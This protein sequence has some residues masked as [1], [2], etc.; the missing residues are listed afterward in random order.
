MNARH[1]SPTNS[2]S[3]RTVRRWAV[4]ITAVTLPLWAGA[5]PVARATEP[6]HR[7]GADVTRV[8]WT[9]AVD[10][11]GSTFRIVTSDP[12]GAHT[13]PLTRP[14]AE[15]QDIHA[16][17]SPDGRTVLFER[18]NPDGSV[19]IMVVGADGRNERV[20]HLGCVDPCASDQNASWTPD[21]RHIVFTRVVGP[22]DLVNDS[23][24]SAVF[25]RADLSGQNIHRVSQTGIDGVYEDYNA[26]FA[27]AG[28]MVFFRLRNADLKTAVFKTTPRGTAVQLT[29]WSIDADNPS[30]SPARSG[31]SRDLIVFYTHGYGNPDE[32]GQAIATI[33]GACPAQC[34][35][36]IRYL[37]SNTALPEQNFDPGWSPNGQRIVYTHFSYDPQSP[38]P[39]GDI[40]TMN[41]DGRNKHPLSTSA[42]FEYS[43]SWGRAAR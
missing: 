18:D 1:S 13:R 24:R 22:F 15:V 11:D 23:A 26:S 7:V 40:W 14:A 4:T 25:Y 37:T 35:G 33:S 21:G 36:H 3:G 42:L 28:Y 5:S 41:W 38:P 43:P 32:I 10:L 30:V 9:Q 16:K 17:I 8:V 34:P 19:Q 31:P 6:I 12:N 2:K 20:L 29:P 27:P 39:H